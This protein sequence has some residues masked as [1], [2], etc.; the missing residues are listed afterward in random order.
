MINTCINDV[1]I[2]SESWKIVYYEIRLTAK[3]YKKVI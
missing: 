3:N 1:F 2:S